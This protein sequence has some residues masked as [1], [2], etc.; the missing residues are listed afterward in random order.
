MSSIE[1]LQSQRA[2]PTS[3]SSTVFLQIHIES[4]KSN[5]TDYQPTY[6]QIYADTRAHSIFIYPTTL[7]SMIILVLISFENT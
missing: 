5:Y 1:N 3:L 7:E 2:D 6:I 4:G